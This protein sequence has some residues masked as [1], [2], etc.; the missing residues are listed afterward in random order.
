[1]PVLANVK[2]GGFNRLVAL[3]QHTLSGNCVLQP[4]AAFT[5]SSASVF[6][7]IVEW[8][9]FDKEWKHCAVVLS[10]MEL[11]GVVCKVVDSSA[12]ENS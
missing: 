8:R 6:A 10:R 1:M 12:P 9:V 7:W 11:S 2:L 3:D 5:P 4:L